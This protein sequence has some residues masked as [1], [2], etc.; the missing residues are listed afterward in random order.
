M[1]DALEREKLPSGRSYFS[2]LKGLK[3]YTKAFFKIADD[4]K[5][6]G[7]DWVVRVA[8]HWLTWITGSTGF[9]AF[10]GND[11]NNIVVTPRPSGTR[12]SIRQ[13]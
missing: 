5:I 8:P 10:A 4:L 2:V 12:A 13:P 11:N 6:P 7:I 3:T 1:E 9:P